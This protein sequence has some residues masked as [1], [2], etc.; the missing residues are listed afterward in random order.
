MT[1]HLVL[2]QLYILV[3]ENPRLPNAAPVTKGLQYS[4]LEKVTNISIIYAYINTTK[5][6]KGAFIYNCRS[7]S[8]FVM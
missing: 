6:K 4:V 3:G 1:H 2:F 7:L 8:L 5:R